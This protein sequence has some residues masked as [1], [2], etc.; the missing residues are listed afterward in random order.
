MI[1]SWLSGPRAASEA[2][3]PR[4][5]QGERLGLPESGPGSIAGFGRRLVALVI[6][7][8]LCYLVALLWVGRD[9]AF[10]GSAG[11]SNTLGLVILVVFAVESIVLV[12]TLG[13]T[14]GMRLMGI[15]V[16]RVG[17]GHPGVGA[18]VL[19]TILLLLVIPAVVW[20]RDGR[21]LHDKAAGTMAVRMS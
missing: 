1:G 19:R 6:D 9:E 18:M 21:G 2:T 3:A 17:G 16:V 4:S 8:F 7:W 14:V 10:S 15:R 11:S 13:F 12:S 20:D 5:Y